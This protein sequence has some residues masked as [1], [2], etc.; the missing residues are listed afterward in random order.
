MLAETVW[1]F[2]KRPEYIMILPE[3]CG[4]KGSCAIPGSR[5]TKGR[6]FLTSAYNTK[7]TVRIQDDDICYDQTN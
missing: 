7:T 2:V 5:I 1:Q 3:K 4:E 6:K